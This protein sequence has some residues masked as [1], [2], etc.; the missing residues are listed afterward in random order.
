MVF[1]T[2]A[3][4]A[5]DGDQ[6]D[7]ELME[8]LVR[9]SLKVNPALKD[10]RDTTQVLDDLRSQAVGKS[11]RHS[12]GRATRPSMKPGRAGKQTAPAAVDNRTERRVK[13]I[14]FFLHQKMEDLEEQEADINAQ[15][16]ILA[17]KRQEIKATAID[18]IA[19]FFGLMSGGAESPEAREGLRQ[20]RT[21]LDQLGVSEVDIARRARRKG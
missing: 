8:E 20:Y 1:K 11:E 17:N 5:T 10:G 18:E 15:E 2:R 14:T 9:K 12:G 4:P 6:D 16:R 3:K 21:F 19:D 13:T 7:I